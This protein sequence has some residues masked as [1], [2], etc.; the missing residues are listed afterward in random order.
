M[1][2]E[3]YASSNAESEEIPNV[4]QFCSI[5]TGVHRLEQEIRAETTHMIGYM[6]Y[7]VI[8]VDARK[9][10]RQKSRLGKEADGMTRYIE[11][12]AGMSE[13]IFKTP[14]EFSLLTIKYL[15]LDDEGEHMQ[16]T[17]VLSIPDSITSW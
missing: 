16:I 10:R 15:F 7:Y 9:K 4:P 6:R 3:A 13:V 2:Y 17:V 14:C 11:E 5:C 1:F 12:V 8:V